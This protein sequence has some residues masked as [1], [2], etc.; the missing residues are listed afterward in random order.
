MGGVPPR[1]RQY[2]E[3]KDRIGDIVNGIV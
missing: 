3:Y 1:D 2:Q